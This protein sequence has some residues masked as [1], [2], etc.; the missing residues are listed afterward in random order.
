MHYWRMATQK[1]DTTASPANALP[2]AIPA[3]DGRGFLL[4]ALDEYADAFSRT[5]APDG[6]ESLDIGCAD[7]VATL[8]ALGRGSRVCACDSEPQHLSVLEA[9]V[10]EAL[11]SRLR[12]VVG[13]LPDVGFPPASFDAI[14]ASRVIHFLTGDDIRLALAAMSDWLKPGGRL[15]LVVDTPYMPG[16]NSIVPAYEAA[17]LA[18]EPWPGYIPDFER[19]VARPAGATPGPRFLNT[20]DPD[21][22]A[23]ECRRAGL[24]VERT[25][26]FGMQRLGASSSGRE[27]AG[28]IA[29]KRV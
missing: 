28:C 24:Q 26:Y 3:L 23:R 16:W 29:L 25:S 10:P 5:A 20:L 13:V 1:P 18:G 7:G 11:R 4:D 9:Q 15:F 8:A 2:G 12:T 17:R 27:H 6:G 22:L 19:V 21:I 14:L